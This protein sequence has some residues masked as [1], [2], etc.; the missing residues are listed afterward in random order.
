MKFIF[1][2]FFNTKLLNKQKMTVPPEAL[3]PLYYLFYSKIFF[4]L[5]FLKLMIPYFFIIGN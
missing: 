3:K 4:T 5:L 2:A 1:N